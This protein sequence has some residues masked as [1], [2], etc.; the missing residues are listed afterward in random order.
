MATYD[1]YMASTVA[2][3]VL[4]GIV[5]CVLVFVLVMVFCYP[6]MLGL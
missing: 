5:T 1:A 2:L 4:F 6:T 3:G